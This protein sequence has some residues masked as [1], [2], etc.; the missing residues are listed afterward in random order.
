[1]AHRELGQL[2]LAD[3]VV[4]QQ[5]KGNALLERLDALLDWTALGKLV[6]VLHSSHYGAPSY[7]PLVMLK[8]LLL[9]QWYGLSDPATEEALWDRLSFRRFCGLSL[10]D[11]APDHSTIQRFRDALGSVGLDRQVFEAVVDQL[12]ARG[13]ILRQGTLI[14]ASLIASVV[15]PPAK[16]KAPVPPGPDG[17]PASQLVKS[18]RDPDAGW[19]RKG[20]RYHFGYKAHV[21][22]DQHSAIIRKAL[23][24][25]ASV[26]DTVPADDLVCGDEAA[27]YADAAYHTHR[28]ERELEARG[29]TAHLMRR[30][31]KHHALSQADKDR[32]KAIGKQRGPVE[33][34]FA[35]AKTSYRWARARCIGMARNTTHLLM[36]CT[37]MNLKRMVVL[38]A[39]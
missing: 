6:G 5:G 32:N 33:Q 17:R 37:A 29:I 19:T 7:P 23:L 3:H 31:N 14:D 10:H 20:G 13:L 28:R 27:V 22:M 21:G 39:M 9:S 34:V 8:V 4:A 25:D 2:S 18:P 26:N 36:L 16:P 38:C 12:D 11:A 15:R 30:G 1:M 35:R 24:T